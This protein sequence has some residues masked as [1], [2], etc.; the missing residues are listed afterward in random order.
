[1]VKSLGRLKA[2]GAREEFAGQSRNGK[3]GA[4]PPMENPRA[5]GGRPEHDAANDGAYG[6]DDHGQAQSRNGSSGQHNNK[7][8]QIRRGPITKIIHYGELPSPFTQ[9]LQATVRD[10]RLSP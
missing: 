1:M 2:N 8:W 4:D 6:G 5:N 9:V 10:H 3:R 7:H